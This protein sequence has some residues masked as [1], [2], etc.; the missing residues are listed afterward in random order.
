MPND[1]ARDVVGYRCAMST[2]TVDDEVIELPA[3]V[4]IDYPGTFRPIPPFAIDI[5]P[6]WVVGEFPGALFAFGTPPRDDGAY[7]NVVVRHRRVTSG[8]TIGEI[9]EADWLALL[10]ERPDAELIEEFFANLQV[11]HY[12]RRVEFPEREREG[13]TTRIDSFVHARIE[14]ALTDDLFHLT[15]LAPTERY[16]AEFGPVFAE[17]LASFRYT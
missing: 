15:W 13:R 14:G 16:D 8:S 12:V 6:L 1:A 11:N 2:T 7:A 17:I 3:A 5:P 4:T 10:E 9:G